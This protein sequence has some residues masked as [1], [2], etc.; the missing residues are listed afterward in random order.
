MFEGEVERVI[1]GDEKWRGISDLRALVE[2]V[3]GLCTQTM[4]CLDPCLD[5]SHRDTGAAVP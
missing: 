4:A 1:G 3:T 2:S 5:V